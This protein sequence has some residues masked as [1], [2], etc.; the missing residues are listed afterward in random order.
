M[1]SSSSCNSRVCTSVWNFRGLA[2]VQRSMGRNSLLLL[3]VVSPLVSAGC[4]GSSATPGTSMTVT[5]KSRAAVPDVVGLSVLAAAN[6]LQRAGFAVTI[7]KAFNLSSQTPQPVVKQES[8]APASML[9]QGR[10]VVLVLEGR[11]CIGSPGVST[12]QPLIMPDVVGQT[13]E[14]AIRHVTDA[15]GFYDVV[16]PPATATLQPLLANYRVTK[17]WPQP[18]FDLRHQTTGFRLPT[19]SATQN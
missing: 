18:G 2:D 4:L 9:L 7:P 8:P 5:S 3:L 13:L 15:T 12:T 14:V 17:Q 11:C 16:V 1:P 10:A 19:L 6:R